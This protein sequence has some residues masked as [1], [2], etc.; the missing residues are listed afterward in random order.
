M[1]VS[2]ISV[3]GMSH[4]SNSYYS[5]YNLLYT[6]DTKWWVVYADADGHKLVSGNLETRNDA[7]SCSRSLHY[8]LVGHTKLIAWSMQSTGFKKTDVYYFQANFEFR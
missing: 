5:N 8:K 2:K 6:N 7:A 3:A 4:Y 1:N